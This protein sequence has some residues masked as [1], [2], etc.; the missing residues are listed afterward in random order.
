[1]KKSSKLPLTSFPPIFATQDF[2]LLN[3]NHWLVMKYTTLIFRFNPSHFDFFPN[4]I[5]FIQFWC[6]VRYWY[7]FFSYYILVV[8]W[9][10]NVG[11]WFQSHNLD[12]CI[13]LSLS[14]H[15]FPCLLVSK[16]GN[17]NCLYRSSISSWVLV[18]LW[19]FKVCE[20]A[21][22]CQCCLSKFSCLWPLTMAF[23]LHGSNLLLGFHGVLADY[24]C[25]HCVGMRQVFNLCFHKCCGC[26]L[27]ISFLWAPL[28]PCDLMW[29]IF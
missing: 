15:F 19:C 25:Q 4:Y 16:F 29:H 27:A 2:F 21:N 9:W 11:H 22:V 23:H 3:L 10:W 28:W 14:S 17:G 7:D 6:N 26:F 18:K 20:D 1:M 24:V 12:H 13:T 8:Q 5:L